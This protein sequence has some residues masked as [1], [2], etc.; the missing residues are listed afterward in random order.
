M[1]IID[2][3]RLHNV[4]TKSSRKIKPNKSRHSTKQAHMQGALWNQYSNPI[5]G[6]NLMK[7]IH[8]TKTKDKIRH[9]QKSFKEMIQKCII[10]THCMSDIRLHGA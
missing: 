4:L 1:S 10:Y 3:A 5:E 7:F 8:E 9:G 6:E 2:R